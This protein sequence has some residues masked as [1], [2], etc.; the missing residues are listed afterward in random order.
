VSDSISLSILGAAMLRAAAQGRLH[1]LGHIYR[2]R[3]R[4]VVTR[5]YGSP[6]IN[7]TGAQL[8]A[9]GLINHVE[10]DTACT[11][12]ERGRA[13]LAADQGKTDMPAKTSNDSSNNPGTELGKELKKAREKADQRGQTGR[14]Q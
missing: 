3:P 9:F 4:N 8:H 13:L 11:I 12:T 2:W 14:S 5:S 7:E 1:R 6:G 10:N